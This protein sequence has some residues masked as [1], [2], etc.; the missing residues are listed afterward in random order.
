[1]GGV[2]IDV[3]KRHDVVLRMFNDRSS[4]WEITDDRLDALIAIPSGLEEKHSLAIADMVDT[5]LVGAKR[6]GM[7]TERYLAL[8]EY[9]TLVRA[10]TRQTVRDVIQRLQLGGLRDGVADRDWFIETMKVLLA[11]EEGS[12]NG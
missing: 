6:W 10:P 7:T 4:G 5:A 3:E 9:L 1:M 11:V 8:R 12:R 2:A